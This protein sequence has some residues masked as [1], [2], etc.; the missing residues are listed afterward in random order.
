LPRLELTRP[1]GKTYEYSNLGMGLLGHALALRAGVKYEDLVI[2]RLCRPLGMAS[3]RMTLDDVLQ[4]RLA[5]P[6]SDGRPVP[7][8]EDYTLPGAG[9][10]L[11]TADDMLRYLAAHFERRVGS[12]YQGA[13]RTAGKKGEEQ[14]LPATAE[15][16]AGEARPTFD[17]AL[18]LCL[19]K[20]R[21]ADSRSTAMG[22][23]WHITSENAVDVIWH[24]GA[25]GGSVSYAGMIEPSRSAVIV[26]A[27]STASVDDLGHKALYL[28]HR[29]D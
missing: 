7:V 17:E 29:T 10:F 23:G 28:L 8:W 15:P 13:T 14:P 12:A 4:S 26:L 25:A 5:Q 19:Q 16:S 24:N 2:D 21:P 20:R 11:S 1:P 3:T 18:R 9:S 6:H 27:N 22:L